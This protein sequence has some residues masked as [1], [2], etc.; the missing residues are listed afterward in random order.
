MEVMPG[1]PLKKG[2]KNKT[3]SKPSIVRL[4]QVSPGSAKE[5]GKKLSIKK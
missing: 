4:G 3:L 5:A 1:D 2:A